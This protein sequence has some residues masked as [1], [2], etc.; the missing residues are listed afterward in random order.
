MSSYIFSLIICT[1]TVKGEKLPNLTT[2]YGQVLCWD[3]IASLLLLL[4]PWLYERCVAT[5]SKEENSWIPQK[6][7]NLRL[8]CSVNEP[9]T[10]WNQSTS[11]WQ[12]IS[13]SMASTTSPICFL[14]DSKISY[15]INLWP[16]FS[17]PPIATWIDDLKQTN[18]CSSLK[19]L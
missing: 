10:G 5:I 13:S 16:L 6:K 14:H 19:F 2:S 11:E 15:P 7:K 17:S 12:K 4:L 1:V 18:S 9:T 3:F 8:R